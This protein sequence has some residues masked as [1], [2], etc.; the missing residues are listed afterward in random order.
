MHCDVLSSEVL[1]AKQ[2]RG[3]SSSD[4]ERTEFG[5]ENTKWGFDMVIVCQPRNVSQEWTVLWMCACR[6]AYCSTY[7]CTALTNIVV[8]VRVVLKRVSVTLIDGS[9]FSMDSPSSECHRPIC[10]QSARAHTHTH[11]HTQIALEDVL[12][13]SINFL[14]IYY[15]IT[16]VCLKP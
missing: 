7:H 1:R 13:T 2:S 10:K 3:I 15:S 16:T 9:F 5:S 14:E 12:L 8:M 4:P 6:C 11:T